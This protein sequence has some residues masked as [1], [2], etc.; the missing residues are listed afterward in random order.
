MSKR[1]FIDLTGSDS[2]EE[3]GEEKKLKLT[4]SE[5]EEE[6]DFEQIAHLKGVIVDRLD[7]EMEHMV[8]KD[9]KPRNAKT[10]TFLRSR[11]LACLQEEEEEFKEENFD[12]ALVELVEEDILEETVKHEQSAYIYKVSIITLKDVKEEVLDMLADSL[13]VLKSDELPFNAENC[14]ITFQDIV[15]DTG[16]VAVEDELWET[17]L[18]DL[19]D[20]GYLELDEECAQYHYHLRPGDLLKRLD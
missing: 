11:I 19:C 15:E 20:A 8:K 1:N 3:G 2:E 6:E 9:G 7:Q 14:S 10:A 17:A 12:A 4:S 16:L 13:Q 18:D 5:E